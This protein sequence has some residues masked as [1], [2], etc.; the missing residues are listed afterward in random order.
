MAR[1]NLKEICR[2]I[3]EHSVLER[4]DGRAMGDIDQHGRRSFNFVGRFVDLVE[5][6]HHSIMEHR[7]PGRV[8]KHAAF[9][10]I[11]VQGFEQHCHLGLSISFGGL[12][13]TPNPAGPF[14]ALGHHLFRAFNREFGPFDPRLGGLALATS[15]AIPIPWGLMVFIMSL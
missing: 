10:I 5:S 1:F 3:P 8:V 2:R 15:D 12:D 7:K 13:Q 14:D 4:G 9:V 11:R 6:H